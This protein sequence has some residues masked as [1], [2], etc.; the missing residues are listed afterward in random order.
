MKKQYTKG[1]TLIELLVVI[2]IISLLSSIVMTSLNS[3]RA[4]GRDAKRVAELHQIQL[5]LEM[6]Y[7]KY[8]TYPVS[9]PVCNSGLNEHGDSWCRDTTNNNGIT[10]IQNWIPGLNEFIPT[11][12]H[13]PKP[14]PSGYWPYHYHSPSANQYWL[15]VGLENLTPV[16]CGGGAVYTWFEGTNTCNWWGANL[17]VRMVK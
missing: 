2:A 11:L 7:D 1:F 16:T 12:P 13:N 4:K 6:Y 3:A 5:A 15:M 10:E 8:G 9:N 17:Y 14:Y